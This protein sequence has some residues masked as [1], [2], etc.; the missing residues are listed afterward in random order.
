M[1]HLLAHLR[2][3]A[4]LQGDRTADPDERE[5]E[6]S[7][8][9]GPAERVDHTE[10]RQQ[11]Q[12]AANERADPSGERAEQ[13]RPDERPAD[14][15]QTGVLRFHAIGEKPRRKARPDDRSGHE[16]GEREERR[17]EPGREPTER[18]QSHESEQDPVER[19]HP[20]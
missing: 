3:V 6:D 2:L 10:R 1:P 11:P 13:D 16:P 9:E 15:D 12:P 4:E 5:A 7:A 17:H 18:G 19:G 14:A 20:G 8:E